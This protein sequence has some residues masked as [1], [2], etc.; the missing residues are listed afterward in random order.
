[1]QIDINVGGVPST[2]HPSST[3]PILLFSCFVIYVICPML[4]TPKSY[5]NKYYIYTTNYVF[6][7]W[8]V[9]IF[10][11][12]QSNLLTEP[13]RIKYLVN[14]THGLSLCGSSC[15]TYIHGYNDYFDTKHL[16]LAFTY[17]VHAII[18]SQIS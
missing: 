4:Q 7:S 3:P 1:M 10:T 16:F 17:F 12:E 8:S 9:T 13:V 5:E 15:F 14:E 11:P 2:P 6:F 18:K